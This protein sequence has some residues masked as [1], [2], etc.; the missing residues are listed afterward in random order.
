M[1]VLA[2]LLVALAVTPAL[3]HALEWPGKMRLPRKHYV[4]MQ[5]IY[6]PGFTIAGGLGEAGGL[7]VLLA[8]L[9]M[10]PYGGTPFWLMLLSLVA[11]ATMHGAY[12][13][14]IHPVNKF[15]LRDETL[16]SV[17]ERFFAADPLSR[18]GGARATH[19]SHNNG[20]AESEWTALRDRWENALEWH[21]GLWLTAMFAV[22]AWRWW[23]ERVRIALV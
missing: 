2:V 23:R 5:P 11:L 7:L 3:A 19:E 18:S 14:L 20:L 8:L 1:Q 16:H 13:A 4:A 22:L 12:W 10:T 6:Y 17:A 9:A 21:L 15:W